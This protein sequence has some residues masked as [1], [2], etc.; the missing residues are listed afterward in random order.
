MTPEEKIASLEAKKE[1]ARWARIRRVY[2]LTKEQYDELNS[3]SC[4]ICLREFTLSIRP[5]IDHDHVSGEVRGIL[6]SYC[7][8]RLVGRHRDADLLDRMASYL[9]QPRRGWIVPKKKKKK[10]TTKKK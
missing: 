4:P 8:H 10:R 6:C 2:G 9:R 3:G 7:N 1:K 5:V